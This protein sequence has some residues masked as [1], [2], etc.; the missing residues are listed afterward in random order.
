[1]DARNLAIMFGPSLVRPNE[2]STVAMVRDM[3]DQC[4]VVESIILHVRIFASPV[5][6]LT[7]LLLLLRAFTICMPAF[8][9]LSDRAVM[10]VCSIISKII[11]PELLNCVYF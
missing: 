10:I 9:Q 8:R 5:D 11:R 2:V 1:M 6:C 3:S 7:Q 4:R